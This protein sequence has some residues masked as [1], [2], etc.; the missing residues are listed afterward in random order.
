MGKKVSNQKMISIAFVLEYSVYILTVQMKN[1]TLSHL[2][3][4]FQHIGQQFD[5]LSLFSRYYYWEEIKIQE[6]Q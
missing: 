5:R 2:C 4:V 1:R 6:S 3:T